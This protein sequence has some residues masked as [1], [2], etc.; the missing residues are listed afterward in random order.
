MGVAMLFVHEQAVY[1][2]NFLP[3]ARR[4][5]DDSHTLFSYYQL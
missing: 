3:F 1:Q 4:M 2:T 5:R